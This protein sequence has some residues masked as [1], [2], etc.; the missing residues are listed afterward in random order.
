MSQ[1]NVEVVR[2][3][4]SLLDRWLEDYWRNP[5][6]V[7]EAAGVG[8]VLDQLDPDA[9]WDWRFSSRTF[10]GRDEIME[11]ATDLIDAVDDWRIR[12]EEFVDGTHGRVLVVFQ[13][14][15][16]GRG[17]GVPVEQRTFSAV[18]VRDGR[19]VRIEDCDDRESAL[20]AIGL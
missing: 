13:G 4:Y 20:R 17:S 19:I 1:E 6:P 9:E 15:I 18:T 14:I 8:R 2:A 16:R 10:R 11:G 12:V 5:G 7:E 3:Y